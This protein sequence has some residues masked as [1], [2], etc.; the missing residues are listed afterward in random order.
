M[1]FV[2]SFRPRFV[3][4]IRCGLGLPDLADP[5]FEPSEGERKMQTIRAERADGRRPKV[6]DEV[7]LY[8]GM[9]TKQCQIVAPRGS[10]KCIACVDIRIKLQ[11]ATVRYIALGNE[12][13]P[14]AGRDTFGEFYM[15]LDHFARRDG[16]TSIGA[17]GQFWAAE[18]PGVEMFNGFL[19]LWN[20]VER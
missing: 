7:I 4:R 16:F 19:T 14:K 9:R 13:A 15:S 18:H 2:F 10:A 3:N 6:G 1:G 11:G 12:P 20:R 17:M 8:T 5:R